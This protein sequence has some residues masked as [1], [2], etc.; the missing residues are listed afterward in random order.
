MKNKDMKERVFQAC[1]SVIEKEGWAKF[2]F[3][4]ASE[5][6]NIPLTVFHDHFPRPSDVM[7]YLF[8][9]IDEQVLKDLSPTE[10]LS[11]KDA[12]F[13]V[14]MA[15][16]EAAEAYKPI[17]KVFWREWIHTPE[18]APVLACQGYSSMT[19]MLEAAHLK[20]GGLKGLLQT[21]GLLVLYLLTLRT[22]LEDDSPDLGQ[23]MV[24]LDKNLTRLE[25]F[26]PFLEMI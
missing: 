12:L 13:E 26:A 2:T 5:K 8:Q 1:L 6:S 22:W 9:K 7:V 4:K 15:R 18:D 11:P 25:R 19:W 17:M 3:Q 23:T 21:Q 24:F 16:F 10:G 20:S 14:L